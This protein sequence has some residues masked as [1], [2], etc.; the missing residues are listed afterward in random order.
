[1]EGKRRGEGTGGE[2]EKTRRVGL[3]PLGTS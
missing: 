1:M 2:K 3:G